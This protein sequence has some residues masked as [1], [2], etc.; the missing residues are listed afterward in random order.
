GDILVHMGD[1]RGAITCYKESLRLLDA[2]AQESAYIIGVKARLWITL[3]HAQR[4]VGLLVEAD[5][6]YQTAQGFV[7]NDSTIVFYQGLVKALDGQIEQ[8]AALCREGLAQ[9]SG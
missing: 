1:D 9:T 5:V 3:G 8:A 4:R 7:P 2:F 6:S